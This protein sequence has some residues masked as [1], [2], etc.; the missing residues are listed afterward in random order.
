[1]GQ[2]NG[3]RRAPATCDGAENALREEVIGD[4]LELCLVSS[5]LLARMSG[6]NQ[7][8][9]SAPTLKRPLNKRPPSSRRS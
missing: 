8:L 6:S 3:K 5:R 1:M 2:Q 7:A 9:E 4:A